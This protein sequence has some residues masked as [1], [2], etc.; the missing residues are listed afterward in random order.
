MT[1]EAPK[2]AKSALRMLPRPLR[3]WLR[4]RT[5]TQFMRFVPVSIAAVITSQVTLVVMIEGF[6]V[7]A[8]TSGVVASMAGA[9]VSYVLSRWAWHRKGRP[10]VLKETLP[11]WAVSV[12]SWLVLGLVTHYAHVWAVSMNLTGLQRVALV[13]GAYFVAN[14][15]TFVARF[16]IFH[17]V[18]FAD[19]GS[20]GRLVSV[21]PVDAADSLA[22]ALARDAE[23]AVA[24]APAAAEAPRVAGEAAEPRR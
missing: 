2:I 5:G 21:D 19:R 1:V 22:V 17:Y 6:H 7:S 14:C 10:N 18:L 9:A 4:S 11:F 3:D 24:P 16:V 15:V 20:A 8:G 13:N 23:P 12:G